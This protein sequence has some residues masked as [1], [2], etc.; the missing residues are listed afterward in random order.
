MRAPP[1]RKARAGGTG[2]GSDLANLV[3]YKQLDNRTPRH[4]QA[5]FTA[6]PTGRFWCVKAI[7][8]NGQATRLGRFDDRLHALGAAVL[9]AAQAEGSV[10]L[11]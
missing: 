11:P 2:L 3:G 1:N 9:L 6:V 4:L 10:V 8:P 5:C 7:A